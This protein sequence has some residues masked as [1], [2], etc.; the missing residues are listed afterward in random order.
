MAAT[1]K[2]IDKWFAGLPPD[3]RRAVEA[4]IASAD[5]AGLPAYLVGGPLRDLLLDAASLDIDISVEGDAIELAQRVA[6]DLDA[7]VKAHPAFGTA[8]LIFPGFTIDLATARSETY[9]RPGALP[10]TTPSGIEEDLR[11][12]DFTVNAMALRLNGPNRGEVLDPAGGIGDLEARRIR[13]LHD[14]SFQDDA[15]RILRAV[16]YACRLGFTIEPATR[17]AL[18]RDV[19]CLDTI[20]PARIH[21]ELARILE[22]PEP[23]AALREIERLGVL[24]AIHPALRFAS[25]QAAAF[26]TIRNAVGQGL[27]LTQTRLALW[28][29]LAWP[30]ALTNAESIARR[31]GL[32]KPQREAV[33]AIPPLRAAAHALSRSNLRPSRIADILAPFPPPT[34]SALAAISSQPIRNRLLDYLRRARNLRPILRGDDLIALGVPQGPA[35]G[36]ILRRLRAARLDG[37]VRT[38]KQ[39]EVFVARMVTSETSALELITEN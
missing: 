25:K 33:A 8:K 34:L 20:S 37:E 29:L 1:P 11:R 19:H 28:P 38:R 39:E 24:R 36:D 3:A 23:E 26:A 10:K 5:A 30:D 16:R 9:S 35:L 18:Q 14:R 32:T 12:R 27:S 17:A 31:I 7:R 21:A 2:L 15:T 22:E 4:V 13:I 6:L